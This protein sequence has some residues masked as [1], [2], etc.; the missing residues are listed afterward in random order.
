MMSR[1][2]LKHMYGPPAAFSECKPGDVIRYLEKG[3]EKSG[4]ILWVCAPRSLGK[5]YIGI[6][7]IVI[8]QESGPPV[9]VSPADVLMSE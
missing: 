8:P 5:R 2:H 6:T 1:E 4:T 3:L 9:V 7:Y